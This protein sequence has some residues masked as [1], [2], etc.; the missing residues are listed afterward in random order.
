[1]SNVVADA[2]S[3]QEWPLQQQPQDRPEA[4]LPTGRI[5]VW[6]DV[7]DKPLPIQAAQLH[8]QTPTQ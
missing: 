8:Q 6:G 2:L 3:R 7:E 4:D 5:S 1:M